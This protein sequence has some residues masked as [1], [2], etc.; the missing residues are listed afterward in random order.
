MFRIVLEILWRIS[1]FRKSREYAIVSFSIIK[2]SQIK[3]KAWIDMATT[4]AKITAGMAKLAANNPHWAGDIRFYFDFIGRRCFRQK[5]REDIEAI[6]SVN[7]LNAGDILSVVGG[8]SEL[9]GNF[10]VKLG[11]LLVAGLTIKGA[12]LVVAPTANEPNWLAAA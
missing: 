12:G 11:P 7:A 1:F 9:T 8:I 5:T 6:H 10:L 3:Q 2:A 4:I